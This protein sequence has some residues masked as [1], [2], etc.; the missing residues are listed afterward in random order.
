MGAPHRQ[1]QPQ[2]LGT[3]LPLHHEALLQ[4]RLAVDAG[5]LDEADAVLVAG[6]Q[7]QQVGRY[8]VVAADPDDVADAQFAPPASVVLRIGAGVENR[9]LE[10][11]GNV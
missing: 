5:G 1:S 4:V 7:Q 2:L 6:V 3:N 10:A 9:C 8:D 11:D